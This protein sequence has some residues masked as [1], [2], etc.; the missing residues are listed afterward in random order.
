MTKLKLDEIG[1][2]S[3]VKLDIVR[4]YASAYST[5]LAKQKSIR[6]HIYIDAFAGAGVHVSKASGAFIPGSPL[7]ALDVV[8]PFK[9]FHF[10]DLDGGRA[11]HLRKLAADRND[12]HVY[13]GDCNRILLDTV[14]AH[15]RYQDF[16]RALCLL[17]PY[18]LNLDWEVIRTAGSMGS[19]E[20]FLNF[21][22]MDMNMNVLWRNPDRVSAK[23]AER[24]NRFWGDDSWKSAA[25]T[26]EANLFG[27]PEKTG[28]K[29]IAESFRKRLKKDAGFAFVPDP[30]PMRNSTGAI[31]YYLF[32]AS[33]NKTGGKIV[34]EIFD[35][36][37]N[38][39]T[40]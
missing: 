33:P 28:N 19:V 12:V 11:E 21:M 6:S 4:K 15:A 26:T 39:G 23:Q 25:Y 14:L 22:V 40:K 24:M 30:M 31:V 35:T 7:N 8:P 18:A 38:R 2:W 10:I 5:I 27:F 13:E 17:D 9:E 20:V 29:E 1:Y 36:Y 16:R 37:R 34:A 3:E 32:F